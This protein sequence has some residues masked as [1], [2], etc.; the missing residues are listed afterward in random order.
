MDD[1][2]LGLI[3]DEIRRNR[4]FTIEALCDEIISPS[5]YSRFVSGKTYLASDSFM[6]L[7]FRLHMTFAMFYKIT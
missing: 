2:N 4:N 5:T 7:V 6:K 3:I 1:K